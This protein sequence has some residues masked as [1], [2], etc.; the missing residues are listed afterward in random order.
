MRVRGLFGR[1]V[2]GSVAAAALSAAA[3]ISFTAAPVGAAPYLPAGDGDPFYA[4]PADLASAAN[5]QVLKVAQAASPFPGSTAQKIQFRSTNSQGEPIAAVTTVLV[6]NGGARHD[7]LSYQPFTNS[8]GLQC[9]PSHQLFRGG[10]QEQQL[11]GLALA[12][13]VAVNVPDHLGPTSAY[14]AARLGGTITLDSIRAV[15]SEPGFR[16]GK[17]RTALAGYSGGAMASAYAAVLAPTY[18]PELNLVGL[19][20]GGTPV[21]LE[22]IAR[23]LGVNPNPLFGLGFAASLG[24]EREY[25]NELALSEQLNPRGVA[26]ANQIRNSCTQQ[27][28]DAG[29]NLKIADVVGAGSLSDDQAGVDALNR[30][31]VQMFPGAPRIPVLLYQGASD[32]LTPTARVQ[33]T[34]AK[35]CRQ[36]TRVQTIIVPGDHGST[37][38]TGVPFA[39][40]Y[41]NDRLSG[42]PAPSTC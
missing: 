25:P 24:L 15:Q 42:V 11:I 38:A 13:G 7:L 36:G 31:S 16:V 22:A 3:I 5:G 34:A 41:I 27:I 14:G 35:W 1:R 19:S 32:Q 10:L 9:A 40:N 17:V 30:N 39:L 33:A 18:A 12:R 8:L 37:I 6:P 20:A 21:N 28:I 23:T 4:A 2:L 26:L 29:A